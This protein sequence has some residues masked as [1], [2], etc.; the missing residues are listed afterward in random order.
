MIARIRGTL[1]EVRTT[2][3][4]LE[5][6]DITYQVHV[7]AVSLPELQTRLGQRVIL[8]TLQYIEGNSAF[9]S[10]VPKLI[11]FV[12]EKDRDFFLR[13]VEVQGIGMNKG[14]RAMIMPVGEIAAAIE[15]RNVATLSKLP[16]I[17]R[18]T[19][20]KVIADLHGKL[21]EFGGAEAVAAA[22]AAGAAA[23]T[24]VAPEIESEAAAVLVQMGYRRSEAEEAVARTVAAGGTFDSVEQLIQQCF[25]K[26]SR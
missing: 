18:R 20:E 14:L 24:S 11:G 26:V 3:V 5:V 4:Y 13:F 6:D 16:G 19:A 25:R 8:W 12:S 23:S 2:S 22:R 7:P 9:G 15:A 21:L 17:G 1:I 10:Q